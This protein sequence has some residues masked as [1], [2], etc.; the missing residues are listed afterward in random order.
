[1]A[2]TKLTA[3]KVT[4]E[5]RVNAATTEAT[6]TPPPEALNNNDE[7]LP[8]PILDD[9]EVLELRYIDGDAFDPKGKEITTD[10]IT[11]AITTPTETPANTGAAPGSP[12][13]VTSASS[14]DSSSS[15]SSAATSGKEEKSDEQMLNLISTDEKGPPTN[16]TTRDEMFK[17]ENARTDDNR[18][19]QTQGR[20]TAPRPVE[21]QRQRVTYETHQRQEHR[22]EEQRRQSLYDQKQRTIH[23]ASRDQDTDNRMISN[24]RIRYMQTSP[25][26]SVDQ[27]SMTKQYA[28][29]PA[30]PVANVV[31]TLRDDTY[32]LERAAHAQYI[33][34]VN[35]SE[36]RAQHTI[37]HTGIIENKSIILTVMFEGQDAHI[38][39]SGTE[40]RIDSKAVYL[41]PRREG[42]YQLQC[43]VYYTGDF[44]QY[45]NAPAE[46]ITNRLAQL[47]RYHEHLGHGPSLAL[48]R[49][50]NGLPDMP[51]TA[52]TTR[53]EDTSD[54]QER[55]RDEPEGR[56][57]ALHLFQD[58]RPDYNQR[59]THGGREHRQSSQTRPAPYHQ[60]RRY[61][62]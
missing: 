58:T 19:Q 31:N 30:L 18:D 17:R 27:F 9:V 39:L 51:T 61:Y 3:K 41:H 6:M 8:P 57:I 33:T 7:Q 20:T 22:P 55:R 2:R 42:K 54:E 32:Q 53:H 46:A 49:Y 38:H 15:A 14:S 26:D 29:K 48:I 12:A 25:A 60:S 43:R 16:R 56:R 5:Q 62:N 34:R 45:T 13:S 21:H 11:A 44:K 50:L 10:E 36:A 47:K 24:V 1:M 52:R 35:E 23:T 28:I 4:L 40:A 59:E 37:R